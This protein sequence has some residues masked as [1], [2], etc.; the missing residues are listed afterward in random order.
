ML[1]A[2]VSLYRVDRSTVTARAVTRMFLDTVALAGRL[3]LRASYGVSA[4][5]ARPV[6]GPVFNG[7]VVHVP[8]ERS[9]ARVPAAPVAEVG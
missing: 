8:A 1:P 7:P 4:P 6:S 9:E 3:Y 2:P 5:T